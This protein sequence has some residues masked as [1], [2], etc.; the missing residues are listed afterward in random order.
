MPLNEIILDFFD[1][2]KKATSG[3]ASFDYE[4]LV[5]EHS[6]LVKLIVCLNDI[7]I[8]E[9]TQ[10]VHRTRAG[11]IS[12]RLVEKL[13]DEVPPKQFKIAIQAKIGERILAREDIK[14]MRKDVTAKCY[15]GDRTRKMKLLKNQAESKRRIRD[16]AKIEI[17]KDVLI[18]ILRK[19]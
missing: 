19:E 16:S 12:R 9:L 14:A 2:L 1:K 11:Q 10:I 4:D 15:G 7:E 18:N 6:D 5:Y 17:S 13:R 3:Y 8:E